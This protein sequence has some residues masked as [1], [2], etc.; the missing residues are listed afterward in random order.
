METI[1]ILIAD[2][3]EVIHN[4]IKD[5]LKSHSNYTIVGNAFN[6]E[7]AIEKAIELQP[8]I[9]FMDISMPKINGIEAIKTLSKKLPSIKIIALSQH[10]ENEYVIEALKAGG[11]GYLFKNSKKDEFINAIETVVKGGRYYCNEL[12]EQMVDKMLFKDTKN[13]DKDNINL[14]NREIEIIQ[15]IAQDKSNQEI[16]DELN[17]SLRTVETHRRNLMQKLKAKSVVSLLKYA[18]KKNLI[19]LK[20]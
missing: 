9:I 1:N 7:E 2:D 13:E 20:K 5:I 3:H 15:K 19:D 14:T 16:A 17:I 8:D 11:K 6:G 18:A 12:T 10:E 4:G